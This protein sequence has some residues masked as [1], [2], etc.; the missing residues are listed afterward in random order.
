MGRTPTA[1]WFCAIY[2]VLALAAAAWT[3]HTEW[4]KL[5]Y[6]SDKVGNSIALFAY[7]IGTTAF[8]ARRKIAVALLPLGLLVAVGTIAWGVSTRGF[9]PNF[10]DTFMVFGR[11]VSLCIM[12]AII[13]YGVRL[14]KRGFLR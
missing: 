13:L 10:Q 9:G 4:P 11:A 2:L 14:A 12:L 6:S 1:Y 3:L 7:L 5:S 8:L